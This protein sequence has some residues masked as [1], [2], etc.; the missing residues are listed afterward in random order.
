MSSI[1]QSLEPVYI[2][3]GM[4]RTTEKDQGIDYRMLSSCFT[5]T[6]RMTDQTLRGAHFAFTGEEAGGASASDLLKTF[7]KSLQ[8]S[9]E[10]GIEV[11]ELQVIGNLGFW[12]PEFLGLTTSAE[13]LSESSAHRALYTH[14]GVSNTISKTTDTS[15]HDY[16]RLTISPKGVAQIKLPKDDEKQK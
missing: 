3:E 8:S 9:K 6:A 15:R 11:A 7:K 13:S 1:T 4:L 2:S 16:V 14:L 5:V 12:P 10:R